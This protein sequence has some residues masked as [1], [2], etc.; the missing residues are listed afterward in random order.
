MKR[1]LIISLRRSILKFTLIKCVPQG[2]FK[3]LCHNLSFIVVINTHSFVISVDLSR[4]KL[5]NETR[6]QRHCY[7]RTLM[8]VYF[9]KG[10]SIYVSLINGIL[11]KK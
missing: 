9:I 1:V 3:T 11:T 4:L 7:I 2:Y 5:N 6:L 8:Y 10:A